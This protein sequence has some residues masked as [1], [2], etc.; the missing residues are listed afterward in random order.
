MKIGINNNN[1]GIIIFL[2]VFFV[3]FNTALSVTK[4]SITYVKP[5]EYHGLLL[6]DTSNSIEKYEIQRLNYSTLYDILNTRNELFGMSLGLNGHYNNFLSYGAIDNNI[7]LGI[8]G[9]SLTNYYNG[10]YNLENYSPEFF[11]RIE[12]LKGSDAA[13]LS[14]HPNNTFLNFQEIIYNTKIPFTRLWYAQEGGSFISADAIFSQNFS[15]GWNFTF[16]FKKMDDRLAFDNMSTDYWNLRFILRYN[17]D[18]TSSLSISDNFTNNKTIT[19]GGSDPEQ[20]LNMYNPI[21]SSPYYGKIQMRNFRHDLNV[22][23]SKKMNFFNITNT[24]Y[25]TSDINERAL[26]RFDE[27]DTLGNTSNTETQIGNRI[28]LDFTFDNIEFKAGSNI[29]TFNSEGTNFFT[30]Y[31]GVNWNLYSRAELKFTKSTSISGGINY[32][33][34]SKNGFIG[35]GERLEHRLNENSSIYLDHSFISKNGLI[36]SNDLEN[37]KTN[38][39]IAGLNLETIK[40]EGYYRIVNSPIFNRL[41]NE[42]YTEQ[43][44]ISDY[45]A[46]GG[47][48]SYRE[49]VLTDLFDKNDKIDL[50]LQ[51]RINVIVGNDE[52]KNYYPLFTFNAGLNYMLMINKSELNIGFKA[53]LLDSKTAPRFIPISNS[54]ITTTNNVGIQTTGLNIY[55]IMKL[56]NAFVKIEWENLLNANYYNVAYYPERGQI[57]KLSVVWSFFD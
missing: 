39:F 27:S 7:E 46:F 5:N 53:G 25:L 30:E 13:V 35:F 6:N 9:R 32:G 4:D 16:G 31:S 11:E 10:K 44:N 52:L 55:S 17:I 40:I 57:V 50:R 12:I 36:Y 2:S 33:D 34:D 14:G 42:F 8:N 56:G 22:T 24:T 51:T 1:A 54:Y 3:S 28:N 19:S 37:E 15:K 45:Q 23:Y 18:S 47:S 29:N 21:N 43:Y 20:S 38:L 41:V 49:Q 48:A 26:P